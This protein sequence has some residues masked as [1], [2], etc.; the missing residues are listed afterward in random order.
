MARDR[1]TPAR[2]VR[3]L[4]EGGHVPRKSLGQNFLVDPNILR[5]IASS[6]EVGPGERVV[7]IGSGP[8]T[9]TELLAERAAEVISVEIDRELLEAQRE[10]LRERKNVRFVPGDFLEFDLEGAAAGGSLVVVGN[11][12]YHATSPILDRV[13]EASAA[14]RVDRAVFLVQKEVAARLAA[15][16]GT[17]DFGRLTLA[18]RYRAEVEVLFKVG[19]AAFRPRPRVDSA[20]IRLRFHHPPA[21]RAADERALFELARVLFS[22]RRKMIRTG[23][24]AAR[25]L[26]P[27]EIAAVEERSGVNLSARPEELDVD[28]W[29]RLSDAVGEIR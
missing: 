15:N 24:R 22:G 5:K 17:K 4:R 19:P 12:P 9:L 20:V 8:G 26:T 25:S 14:A 16:P 28:D 10:R 18:V 21:V 7:E 2:E 6:A 1:R 27:E 3:D 29:C 13:L 11:I 23:L